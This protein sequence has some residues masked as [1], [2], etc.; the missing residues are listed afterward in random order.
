MSTS[1]AVVVA[2]LLPSIGR[3]AQEP[4]HEQSVEDPRLGA[5]AEKE[6]EVRGARI[7]AEIARLGDAAL[8]AGSYYRGD[9]TGVNVQI[10][11]APASGFVF[12][13]TGCL[14]VVDRDYGA[15]TER[16]GRLHL[17]FS[18]P[19]IQQGS[20]QLS[21]VLVPARW[22]E[23]R[24][25]IASDGLRAFANATNG[26]SEPRDGPHGLVL[27]RRGDENVE[28]EGLPELPAEAAELLLVHPVT[29]TITELHE[30]RIEERRGQ[31]YRD[32]IATVD[33]GARHGLRAG[34]VVHFVED[35]SLLAGSGAVV[36]VAE[37][38]ARI[39]IQGILIEN[40]PAPEVGWKWSTRWRDRR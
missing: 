2:S 7:R 35:R 33:R 11:L 18:F 19:E 14:G 9:G 12:T 26:G 16:D 28:V 37:S 1:C 21:P 40:A 4:A 34:H 5:A 23:R 25:L 27:L 38:T 10:D 30:R 31:R 36:D 22:G 15:C 3:L 13:S 24:Y 20:R 29:G 32:D 8:W 39:R 17:E 6:A